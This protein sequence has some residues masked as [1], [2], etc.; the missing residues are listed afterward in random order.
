MV[1]TCRAAAT[2]SER[3]GKRG[4]SKKKGKKEEQ[5]V[6]RERNISVISEERKKRDRTAGKKGGIR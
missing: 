2:V 6:G 1:Q 4:N 3:G 5:M